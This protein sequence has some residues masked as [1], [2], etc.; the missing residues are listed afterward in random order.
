MSIRPYRPADAALLASLFRAAVCS[1]APGDYTAPQA[2]AWASSLIDEAKFAERCAVKSTWVA[3]IEDRIAGFS[4]LESDGHIDMLYVHPHLQ[5]RGVAPALL[6]HIEKLARALGL[7]RLYTEASITARA[8]FERMGFR[9]I[10]SQSVAVHGESLTHYR[11][12]K[13]LEALAPGG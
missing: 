6:G 2:R 9:V 3:E 8:V 1:V 7:A 5:R 10:A 13:R 4:D 12:E 11:M